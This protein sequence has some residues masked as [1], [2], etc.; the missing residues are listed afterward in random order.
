MIEPIFEKALRVPHNGERVYALTPEEIND[1]VRLRGVRTELDP[2]M[3]G[4]SPKVLEDL[5]HTSSELVSVDFA[6]TSACNFK[7][8][9][10]YRPDKEW[11]TLLINFDT[12]ARVIKQCI[13]LG[14]RYF[15]LTGG[16][17]LMYAG[18]GTDNKKYSYFDVVDMIRQ[19]YDAAGID[20]KVLTFSDVALID[21]QKARMLAERKVALC[22]KR[23]TLDYKIQDAIVNVPGGSKDMEK[24]YRNLFD[25]GYGTDP[26][27]AVSVNHVLR[28]GNF[29]TLKGSIDLHLWIREH[30][31]EHSIVPIHYC[32]EAMDE[33]QEGGVNPLEVKVLYDI[34][35]EIDA[36]KFN[37][38]WKVFSAF[39]KNKTCN[40]PGRGVH[41]RATGDVTCCSES[42]LTGEY[43]FG[44]ISNGELIDMIRSQKF[45][46]FREEFAQR[47]GRYICNPELCD[48]NKNYLCRGG[49]A[50]RSAYSILDT[51]T[52]LIEQN[53]N[54]SSYSKGREDPLCPGWIVLAQKQGVLRKGLYEQTVDSILKESQIEP[55]C[56]AEIRDKIVADFNSLRD[57]T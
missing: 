33:C 1:I 50:T 52:G 12:L 47:N 23:D 51:A 25:A 20:V 22:L 56:A 14:V 35:A 15:V 11:G 41:I 42:P 29:N 40:R 45:I 10:C 49:C 21:K 26:Q 9:H 27:L 3:G 13:T 31:M 28:K 39:P 34:L 4:V 55:D 48:L 32:G 7:C 46:D 44:N 6:L 36:L 2:G 24:G 18:K 30:G 43:V 54:L 17:P 19:E 5:L 8:V 37:D 53:T 38:P 57:M 16:E